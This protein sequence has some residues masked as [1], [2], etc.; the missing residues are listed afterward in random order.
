MN[1][2]HPYLI[3]LFG[4]LRLLFE[5]VRL[6]EDLSYASTQSTI[7]LWCNWIFQKLVTNVEMQEKPRDLSCVV[8]DHNQEKSFWCFLQNELFCT[9]MKVFCLHFIIKLLCSSRDQ[10]SE[11]KWFK[12]DIWMSSNISQSYFCYKTL[13]RG[14]RP[15]SFGGKIYKKTILWTIYCRSH[16]ETRVFK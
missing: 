8:S 9:Y 16:F 12:K 6:S 14:I 13:T 5:Q 2:R 3:K 11:T 7:H 10:P 4:F 15:K 1:I